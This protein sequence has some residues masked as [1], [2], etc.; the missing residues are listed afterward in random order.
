LCF[1]GFQ[2]L[3]KR[4]SW[5]PA[6]FYWHLLDF[7]GFYFGLLSFTRFYWVFLGLRYWVISFIRFCLHII[8]F[9]WVLLDFT[10]FYLVLLGLADAET[11]RTTATHRSLAMGSLILNPA[12]LGTAKDSDE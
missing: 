6:W 5:V 3:N 10:G 9:Y 2:V 7:T 1:T 11:D 4:V 12:K 8:G